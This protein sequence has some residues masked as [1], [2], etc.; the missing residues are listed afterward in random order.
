MGGRHTTLLHAW[1]ARSGTRY[2]WPSHMPSSLS[3]TLGLLCQRAY[4]PRLVE[5]VSDPGVH[6]RR[7]PGLCGPQR[8]FADLRLY[9]APCGGGLCH[10]CVDHLH[11]SV[12]NRGEASLGGR[13]ERV[14]RECFGQTPRVKRGEVREKEGGKDQGKGSVPVAF[15]AA[16]GN[17][18]LGQGAGRA[19][20]TQAVE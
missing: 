13:W 12:R 8:I 15:V 5:H 7:H 16:G 2:F 1:N 9:R 10:L 3:W 18:V 20:R 4:L 11:T 17:A 6:L 14:E 19:E